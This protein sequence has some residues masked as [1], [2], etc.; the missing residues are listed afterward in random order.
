MMSTNLLPMQKVFLHSTYRPNISKNHGEIFKSFR[1][2]KKLIFRHNDS[3]LLTNSKQILISAQSKS[4]KKKS[5]RN[6]GNS[7]GFICY[8]ETENYFSQRNRSAEIVKISN[9]FL[10][11]SPCHVIQ[12]EFSTTERWQH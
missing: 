12:D 11:F 7:R 4:E 10:F 3:C 5:I 9:C 2:R 8:R 6:T 1:G